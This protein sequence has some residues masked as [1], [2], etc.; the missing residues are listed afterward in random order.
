MMRG[1]AFTEDRL[2]AF[3]RKL[4]NTIAHLD[5][6]NRDE[7][8][9]IFKQGGCYIVGSDPEILHELDVELA[10]AD[11]GDD[12]NLAYS[13]EEE[14]RRVHPPVSPRE[15]NL[16]LTPV[17]LAAQHEECQWSRETG[18]KVFTVD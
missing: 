9:G 10:A 5:L 4:G 2:K 18:F 3:C 13:C 8:E 15:F 6:L 16:F 17:S 14:P 7:R 12:P 11:A 1:V